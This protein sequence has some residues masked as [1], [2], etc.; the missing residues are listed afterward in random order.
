LTWAFDQPIA[1]AG[2]KFVLVALADFA[3]DQGYCYPFVETIAGMTSQGESTVR[4]HIA[5]LIADGLLRTE[6]R[7]RKD[8]GQTSN[9]YW[10]IGFSSRPK[11]KTPLSKSD[12]PPSRNQTP[13]SEN[14]IPPLQ[15]PSSPPLQI[16]EGQDKELEP[17][18]E[19][20]VEPP[21]T[22]QGNS[23]QNLGLE[24]A[25]AVVENQEQ[26]QTSTPT[27]SH[28]KPTGP[29]QPTV[30]KPNSPN[31][32][33]HVPPA[34]N[35]EQAQSELELLLGSTRC[36]ARYPTDYQIYLESRKRWLADLAPEFI[37]E[38]IKL[39]RLEQFVEKSIFGACIKWLEQPSTAPD[40]AR[41][42]HKRTQHGLTP[43][44]E[45]LSNRYYQNS[46]GRVFYAV[47]WKQLECSS[48]A[49]LIPAA[50]TRL[51]ELLPEDYNPDTDAP[52]SAPTTPTA[53]PERV[54]ADAIAAGLEK[55]G[56][57]KRI[58]T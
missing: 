15:I 17:S 44:L 38:C 19:P 6:K 40:S 36:Q 51:W 55:L 52:K 1:P 3:D 53:M 11:T 18:F 23:D 10:L 30:N 13:A 28:T 24:T 49:G 16:S 14:Q 31:G 50:S 48:D 2:K 35:L 20:S 46:D 5:S 56:I 8:G 39:A 7:E 25:K 58:A 45:R 27:L 33:E 9:G 12:T 21:T 34:A 57:K 41:E 37:L 22:L 29:I 54:S 26:I 47:T 4:T 32:F 43:R 42:I